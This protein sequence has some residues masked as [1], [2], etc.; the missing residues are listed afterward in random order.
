MWSPAGVAVQPPGGPA[1]NWTMGCIEIFVRADVGCVGWEWIL[2]GPSQTVVNG[3]LLF[4]VNRFLL[5]RL[6]EATAREGACGA[7][8]LSTPNVL[9]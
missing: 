7:E 5:C 6:V 3:L 9:R 8:P 1:W 2:C 4:V